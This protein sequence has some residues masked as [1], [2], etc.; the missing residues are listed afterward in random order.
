MGGSPTGEFTEWY[1]NFS[2]VLYL[3]DT[4][5]IIISLNALISIAVT[6]NTS[7]L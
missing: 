5:S 7:S 1:G 3:T 4:T 6:L 2:K